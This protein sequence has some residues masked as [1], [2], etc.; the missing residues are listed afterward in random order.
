LEMWQSD[1]CRLI[2]LG[3]AAV[4][5]GSTIGCRKPPPSDTPAAEDSPEPIFTSPFQ[6]TRP[7]V[8]YVGDA[9]CAQCHPDQAESY[10]RHPMGRSLAPV[11]QASALERYDQAAHNPFEK[12][13]LQFFVEKRGLQM[14]HQET[15]R[16]TQGRV[17]TRLDGEVQFAIGSGTHGRTYLLERDGYLFQ[18]P[19]SWYSR[20]GVWDLTPSFQPAEHFDRPAQADCLFCHANQV[21]PIEDSLNRYR[22]PLFRGYAI[23]CERCHGPG[24]LHVKRRE[25]GEEV[26]GVDY[27]IVNP[28]HLEPSLRNSICQQC[29]LQG[30]SRIVR[31][32]RRLFDYRPGLPLHQFLSV[33]L[34]LPEFTDQQR[35]GS[36]AVQM[37]ASRCFQESKGKLG[38]VSCHDPHASPAA[39]A[40]ASHYRSRCLVC[41]EEKSCGLTLAARRTRSSEDNCILCHM[42]RAESSNIAHTAVT[43][44]RIVRL[45][46]KP[47]PSGT[48]ARPLNPSEV[49]LVHFHHELVRPDDKEVSRDLGLALAELARHVPGMERHVCPIALPLL[50]SAVQSWPEDVAAREGAA[51]VLWRLD[52]QAEALEAFEKVLETAPRRE[53]TLTYAAVL[54]S[55]LEQT[56]AAIAYWRRAVEVNPWVSQYHYQLA[57]DLAQNREWAEAVGEC[58]TARKLNTASE[59]IRTLL[60]SCYLRTGQREQAR[61]ELETLIA[62]KPADQEVLRRWFAEQP[63]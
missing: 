7:S 6:N 49:P 63:P 45:A 39:A 53:S 54:A 17:L 35:S 12:E 48:P 56:R 58:E 32:G 9:A 24:E 22:A 19:I 52:R 42:P 44:H 50:Q 13:G 5:L 46:R 15:R 23:G 36:H 3:L 61:K 47:S 8:K 10:S 25:A 21:E 41:H 20:K 29:H 30:E 33:F 11:S 18:S 2:S 62:M 55:S 28:H 59:E 40:K 51:F 38:C 37:A 1:L 14:L 26:N 34:R 27:S 4:V 31:R 57:R 43:D 60:I 16:D